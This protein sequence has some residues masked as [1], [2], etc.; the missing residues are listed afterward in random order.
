MLFASNTSTLRHH[1][2]P[3]PRTP[4]GQPPPIYPGPPPNTYPIFCWLVSDIM[5]EGP[6]PCK[7]AI[8]MEALCRTVYHPV[9]MFRNFFPEILAVAASYP[10]PPESHNADL[11]VPPQAGIKP[12]IPKPREVPRRATSH[13]C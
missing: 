12:K 7:G 13:Q 8:T 6:P 11:S 9:I 2:A 1:S 10:V 4:S 3:P 5:P